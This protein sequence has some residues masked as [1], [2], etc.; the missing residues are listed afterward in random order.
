MLEDRVKQKERVEELEGQLES[1]LARLSVAMKDLEMMDE[2]YQNVYLRCQT[3]IE[4]LEKRTHEIEDT[5]EVKFYIF[6]VTA[7]FIGFGKNT[8]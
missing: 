4:K 8:T 2:H 6:S 1:M 3:A 5:K 7:I